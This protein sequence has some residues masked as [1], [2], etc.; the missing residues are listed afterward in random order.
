M[1][2]HI[3]LFVSVL[4]LYFVVSTILVEKLHVYL[5]PQVLNEGYPLKFRAIFGMEKLKVVTILYT[6]DV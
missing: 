4:V 2:Y 1:R 3:G 6:E 5:T